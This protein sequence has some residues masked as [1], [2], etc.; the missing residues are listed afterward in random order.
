M[1]CRRRIPHQHHFLIV[2]V[3]AIHAREVDPDRRAPQVIGIRHQVM[4]AQMPLEN[5]AAGFNRLLFGHG[6]KP[7]GIPGGLRAFH[8]ECCGIFVEL[9]GVG[10]DPSM[11]SLFKDKGERVVEFLM[12]SKPDEFAQARVYIGLEMRRPLAAHARVQTIRRHHQIVGGRV[13]LDRA[14]LGFKQQL[15][16]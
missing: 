14:H 3:F 12:R 16:A 11:G 1:C 5:L 13:I 10:P 7:P 4:P 6:H 9:V 8:D 2:P 15:Y